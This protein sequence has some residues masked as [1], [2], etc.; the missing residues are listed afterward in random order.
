MPRRVEDIIRSDKRSIRSVSVGRPK[1]E[2]EES[3]E[4][5]ARPAPAKRMRVTPPEPPVRSRAAKERPSGKRKGT[6][7]S[8]IAFLAVVIAVGAAAFV[9]S[10][11]F[12]RA[13]FSIVPLTVPVSVD[14]MTVVASGSPGASGL[15]Y[16]VTPFTAIAS[17]S[18]PAVDGAYTSSK[19]SGSIV[20]YNS[21]NTEGQRLIAGTRFA[22]DNGLIYRLTSSVFVPGYKPAG[23]TATPGSVRAAVVADQAGS[24]YD[25][26]KDQGSGLLKVVAYQGSPRYDSIYA[27]AASDISGGF[28]GARKTVNP[29]VL[30]STTADIQAAL[31]KSL[32]AK[33]LASVPDGYVTY[34]GAYTVSFA[35][36]Q[37][38]GETA[39]AATVTV[40]GI[41]YSVAFK[42]TDLAARLAGEQNIDK[43]GKSPYSVA[44]IESLRFAITNPGTFNAAR[45]NTLIARLNGSMTLQGIVPVAQ[46]RQQLAGLPLSQTRGVFAQYSSVIDMA[47][48]SGELFPSWAGTVP[49]DENRILISVEQP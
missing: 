22:A 33:A 28:A 43:F 13:T 21:Y 7:I 27:R 29:A 49:K 5:K 42:K 16:S 1:E 9:A 31:T 40:T 11:F 36:A 32:A 44:G 14:N 35:P 3:R 26:G 8:L 25:M 38:G 19:A 4:E 23:S 10:E 47:K 17:T 39:H 48:S 37:I 46:L 45:K 41:L 6:K 34:D 15:S 2:P 12:S 24:Q 20:I 18:I 30:A